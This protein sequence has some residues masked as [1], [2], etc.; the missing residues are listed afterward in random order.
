[1]ARTS[2]EM[3]LVEKRGASTPFCAVGTGLVATGTGVVASVTFV[4][5][6]ILWFEGL[7]E[8]ELVVEATK[9]KPGCSED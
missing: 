1:M 8:V 3:R 2:G 4:I 7:Y 5:L 9:E 6:E